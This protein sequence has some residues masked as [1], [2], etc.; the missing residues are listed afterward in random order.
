MPNNR[1]LQRGYESF[2]NEVTKEVDCRRE[3][4]I[5]D[6]KGARW[7]VAL[8]AIGGG[9]RG[10]TRLKKKNDRSCEAAVTSDEKKETKQWGC[11]SSVFEGV[12][13]ENEMAARHDGGCHLPKKMERL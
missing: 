7:F 5:S 10:S 13:K 2:P 3:G 11:S 4:A 1:H 12:A 8:L 9:L 6:Q